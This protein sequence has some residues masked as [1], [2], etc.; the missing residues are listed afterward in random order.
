M[1]KE[2][3]LTGVG[4]DSYGDWY[5]RARSENAATVLPGPKTIT[6]AAHNVV[7]DFFAFGGWP[8]LLAYLGTLLMA[9]TCFQPLPL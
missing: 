3:P 8:L 1:G 4:M 2:H 7:I 5:R 9:G 6:N